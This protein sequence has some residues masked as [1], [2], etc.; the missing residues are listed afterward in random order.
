MDVLTPWFL[1]LPSAK[2]KND[3]QKTSVTH[4]ERYTISFLSEF[5]TFSNL[6]LHLSILLLKRPLWKFDINTTTGSRT[7]CKFY[8]YNKCF[9]T[10]GDKNGSFVFNTHSLGTFFLARTWVFVFCV[11]CI[12]LTSE[13]LITTP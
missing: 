5:K 7:S 13:C 2:L 12:I 10:F 4:K 8:K 9:N 3:R 6:L 1:G 11:R